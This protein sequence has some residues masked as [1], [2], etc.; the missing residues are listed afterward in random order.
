MFSGLKLIMPKTN[1]EI[2]ILG[3]GPDPWGYWTNL[4]LHSL[5]MNT[6]PLSYLPFCCTVLTFHFNFV[7]RLLLQPVIK[8]TGQTV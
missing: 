3:I 8:R 2:S 4:M 1:R 5:C 6:T 7:L